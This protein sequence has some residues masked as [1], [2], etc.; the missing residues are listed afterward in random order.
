MRIVVLIVV[1]IGSLLR[2][3]AIHV[4]HP[5]VTRGGPGCKRWGVPPPHALG[6]VRNID[7][8]VVVQLLLRARGLGFKH[9][10]ALR[11]VRGRIW[12]ERLLRCL[13]QYDVLKRGIARVQKD[14][15]L[16]ATNGEKRKK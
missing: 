4:T 15:D 7:G 2:V 12:V 3:W 13:W 5:L 14:F 6:S 1:L 8:A 16:R 10:V 11:S 9:Q